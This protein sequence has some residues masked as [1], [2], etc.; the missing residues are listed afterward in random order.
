MAY[1]RRKNLHTGI[2]TFCEHVVMGE[3]EFIDGRQVL[4]YLFV[5]WSSNVLSRRLKEN[6]VG[7]LLEIF[8][9]MGV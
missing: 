3:E 5:C 1:R 4:L 6:A 8:R 7:I 2:L 9:F